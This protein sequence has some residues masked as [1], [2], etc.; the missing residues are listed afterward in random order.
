[1]STGQTD[2]LDQARLRP[3][4]RT[5]YEAEIIKTLIKLKNLGRNDSTLRTMSCNLR[6]LDRNTDLNNPEQVKAYTANAKVT[7]A[8]K[9]KLCQAYNNYAKA[10][11]I[12]WEK[13]RYKWERKIPLIPTTENVNR[14]IASCKPDYA[15]IFTILAETGLE[16]YELA[17][18][19]RTDIDAERGIINATGCKGHNS[20]SF[21]LKEKTAEMLRQ[22]INRHPQQNPFPC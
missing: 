12:Q 13:P 11:S 22:Y 8:T 16:A 19:R 2:F 15:T 10:N 20:R 4:Q 6:Q 18:T 17:T 3:Q 14:I 5:R 7:N 21:K 9:N 1:M